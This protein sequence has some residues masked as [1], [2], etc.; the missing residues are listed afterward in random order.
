MLTRRALLQSAALTAL[1]ANTMPDKAGAVPTKPTDSE[2]I[3]AEAL[4]VDPV[5]M[6]GMPDPALQS[7][8]DAMLSFMQKRNVP[9]GSLAVVKNGKLV[10]ARGYGYADRESGA[11][12]Q[13]ASLFRIASISK[14]ITAV[15]IM[16]L[17]QTPRYKLTLNTKVLP[18]LQ[19]TPHLEPGA[20]LDPRL[21]QITIGHLLHHAAGFDRDKSGDPMFMPLQI[22]QS[23]GTP[24]PADTSAI[25]RY[26]F[27]R[28]LDFEP[29]T[30]YVYSNFGYCVLGRIIEKV[31]G[32]SYEAYV[33]KNV[34]KPL[35]VR[36]MTLGRTLRAYKRPDE[37]CYYQPGATTISVFPESK[38]A[39]VSWCYGGFN[40][41]AMDAHGGWLASAVDLVRFAAALDVPQGKP[42]L[43]PESVE[44]LY[45][46]PAP[47][48]GL[49][50]DGKPS[51]AY[52]G[53]GWQVR[54]VG[55]EVLRH[56]N[57]WHNGSLP[58]TNT[59][60]VRRWDG[61]TW[62]MLFNQRSEGNMPP[63]GAIDGAMHEAAAAVKTWPDHDL[64]QEYM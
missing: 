61:L 42:L 18:L 62:A 7:F 57:I 51:A 26:V 46:R 50:S 49:E 38:G 10:Y 64:F 19:V 20:H 44:M 22:A 11:K 28:P 32:Q 52:Y 31:T 60:L 27:G 34:L 8:D 47:P 23:V 4:S 1:G 5:P 53:S 9:G 29:G 13:I 17:L 35:S 3:T 14:P 37:V 33:Q 6:T 40:M 15:A 63:D 48:L 39:A 45:A 43:T 30:R 54:P 25:I 55:E 59:W 24:A 41:E 21:E 36:H 16:T 12:V 2:P 58:G 56:R